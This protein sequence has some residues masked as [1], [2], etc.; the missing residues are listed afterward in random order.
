MSKFARGWYHLSDCCRCLPLQWCQL[1]DNL[2]VNG[3]D[4]VLLLLAVVALLISQRV[5]FLA[6]VPSGVRDT[7]LCDLV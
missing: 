7:R 1:W 2:I 3:D 4:P 6:I 5:S